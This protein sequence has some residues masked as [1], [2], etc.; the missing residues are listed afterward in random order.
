[1]K[2]K[3]SKQCFKKFIFENNFKNMK[4]K[5]IG[6]ILLGAAIGAGLIWLF[7]SDDGKE[8][9]SKIKEKAS[10]LKDELEKDLKKASNSFEDLNDKI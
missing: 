2:F 7:T 9:I 6:S 10:D 1:L 4:S 8:L 5:D 3:E